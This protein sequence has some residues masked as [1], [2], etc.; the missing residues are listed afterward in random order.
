MEIPPQQTHDHHLQLV[1]TSEFLGATPWPAFSNTLYVLRTSSP[2]EKIHVHEVNL[3]VIDLVNMNKMTGDP[4][5]GGKGPKSSK[6]SKSKSRADLYAIAK[7]LNIRN[8]SAMTR[9]ELVRN[10]R[11][12]K[13]AS[14]TKGR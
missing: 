9:D 5:Q 12:A 10:I 3:G 7:G 14:A 8:R 4:Q 11:K 13:K 6:S 1:Y 2:E